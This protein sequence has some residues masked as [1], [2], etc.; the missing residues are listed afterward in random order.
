MAKARYQF[1]ERQEYSILPQ[2]F[3]N[4]EMQGVFWFEK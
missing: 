2:C 4:K 3:I 1:T